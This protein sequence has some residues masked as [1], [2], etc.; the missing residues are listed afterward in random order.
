MDKQMIPYEPPD[1]KPRWGV[2]IV[3]GISGALLVIFLGLLIQRVG[4]TFNKVDPVSPTAGSPS[5]A[6]QIPHQGRWTAQ[7][8]VLTPDGHV[9]SF[10]QTGIGE[11]IRLDYSDI[12]QG[13]RII[14][15]RYQISYTAPDRMNGGLLEIPPKAIFTRPEYLAALTQTYYALYDADNRFW[16]IL[17]EGDLDRY[18]QIQV[19]VWQP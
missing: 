7:I 1:N 11:S 8:T 4:E 6:L 2:F 5:L 12:P 9:L 3:T 15:Y 14:N 17:S 16:R 18:P 10:E 13:N 19:E